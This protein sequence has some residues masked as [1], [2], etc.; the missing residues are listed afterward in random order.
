MQTP[1]EISAM[2]LIKMMEPAEAYIG[3]KITHTTVVTLPAYFNDAQQQATKDGGVIAGVQ[4]LRM[5][6]EP[7]AAAIMYSLDKKGGES[8]HDI[9]RTGTW[10]EVWR[11]YEGYVEVQQGWVQ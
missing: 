10:S 8:R 4:V 5:S 2:V 11:R 7:T 6:N 9:Y 1:S 3:H